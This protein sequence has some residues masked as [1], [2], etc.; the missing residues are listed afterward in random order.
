MIYS[1]PEDTFEAVLEG[2][3]TGLAGT[4]GVRVTDP[5]AGTT[6][7]ART[8]AEISESPV[9]SGVYAVALAAPAVEGTYLVVWDDV[10]G[11][12]PLTPEH[13]WTE[14]LVVTAVTPAVVFE[15]SATSYTTVAECRLY[16]DPGVDLPADDVDVATLIRAAERDID[17]ASR[18]IGER[19]AMSGLLLTPTDLPAWQA[20][21]LSRATCAQVEYRVTMGPDFFIRAQHSRVR[22][23]DFMTEGEL[24]FVGPKALRELEG[25]RLLAPRSASATV[26]SL[27]ASDDDV[28]SMIDE[29]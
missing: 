23:P 7:I 10:P 3:P 9:G 22:G 1:Q 15:P 18:A 20:G 17:T 11:G 6:V 29:W 28:P 8:T 21:A 16:V 25:G 26:R 13:T 4:L 19:N 14:Q 2:A 12:D 5:P 27:I 24:P